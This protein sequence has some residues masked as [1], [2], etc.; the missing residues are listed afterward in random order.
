M[1]WGDS[2][3]GEFDTG[4]IGSGGI[5]AYE[6]EGGYTGPGSPSASPGGQ[7]G[8]TDRHGGSTR[9]TATPEYDRHNPRPSRPDTQPG[10]GAAPT[11]EITG[12]GTST[13]SP[14]GDVYGDR[15]K[16]YGLGVDPK[17]IQ[18]GKTHVQFEKLIDDRDKAKKALKNYN[19]PKPMKETDEGWK[20]LNKAYNNAVAAI[21]DLGYVDEAGKDFETMVGHGFN[22]ITA[23]LP[24]NPVTAAIQLAKLGTG[25]PTTLET[26]AAITGTTDSYNTAKETIGGLFT[27]KTDTTKGASSNNNNDSI[28]GGSGEESIGANVGADTLGATT[29]AANTSTS[30]ANTNTGGWQG[31]SEG[32]GE[33]STSIT[34][35]P[36]SSQFAR[37]TTAQSNNVDLAVLNPEEVKDELTVGTNRN[38]VRAFQGSVYA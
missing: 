25:L 9:G 18:G 11:A 2:P 38:T 33:P 20:A 7:A 13:P 4:G 15:M 29:T 8:G 23:G 34:Q 30:V 26:A 10:I 6:G 36:S 16:A 14:G 31:G 21:N 22:M 27:G 19:V 32:I 5:G 12:T 3:G 35:T 37:T 17:D 1:S 28:S 24:L